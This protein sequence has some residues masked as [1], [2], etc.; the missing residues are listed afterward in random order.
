M[1]LEMMENIKSNVKNWE[2]EEEVAAYIEKILRK[3]AF[4]GSGLI[5]GMGHAVYTLSDPRAILLKQKAIELAKEKGMDKEFN[6]YATIEK[7]TPGIFSEVKQASKEICA[8]VDFYSGFV[9]NMLNIPGELH[10]PIFAIA[11]IAGWCAHRVEE[12]ISG[13]RIIRPAYK[14][15]ADKREYIKIDNR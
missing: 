3:E 9:Y 1:V 5:Y 10:T 6:L 14:N 8:N 11:R 7:L 12:L 2:D 15:I 4:D 13:G